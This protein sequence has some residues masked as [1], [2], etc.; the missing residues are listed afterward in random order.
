M[1]GRSLRLA[2]SQGVRMPNVS[3][4]A[5]ASMLAAM[6]GAAGAG[7]CARVSLPSWAL[8]ASGHALALSFSRLLLALLL[9]P[10][11][12]SFSS[13]SQ[14]DSGRRAHRCR[15][16]GCRR[17]GFICCGCCLCSAMVLRCWRPCPRW[18]LPCLSSVFLGGVARVVC[19]DGDPAQLCLTGDIP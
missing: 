12:R 15:C 8:S 14:L 6:V 1:L 17:D 7:G 2:S 3:F 18:A 9:V 10:S 4:S 5:F 19:S 13:L 16:R 11:Q